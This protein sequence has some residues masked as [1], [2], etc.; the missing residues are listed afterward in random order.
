MS[1]EISCPNDDRLG[2]FVRGSL[3]ASDLEVFTEHI[4][5]CCACL[6]RVQSLLEDD[7]LIQVVRDARNIAPL[8]EDRE[9][10][11]RLCAMFATTISACPM[12]VPSQP[13]GAL[14]K[15]HLPPSEWPQ[16][17]GYRILRELGHGGMGAVYCARDENMQRLVAIK[18]IKG[19]FAT[20]ELLHRFNREI[21]LLAGVE[22][23]HIMKV[24]SVGEWQASAEDRML[25]Y[26][27]L[28]YVDGPD[29][30]KCLGKKPADPVEAAKLVRLLARAVQAIHDAGII[31]RDLK[32]ANVLL[33]PRADEPA[34]NSFWGCPKVADFGL[35][36]SLNST[37]VLTQS[38]VVLGTPAYMAPEQA[39]GKEAGKPADVYALGAI[40]YRMLTGKPPFTG[41]GIEIIYRVRNNSPDPP[42]ADPILPLD[43][44]IICLKCLEKEPSERYASASEL[45]EDLTRFL[46]RRRIHALPASAA[47][48][49]INDPKTVVIENQAAPPGIMPQDIH[50]NLIPSLV[51]P[52]P[53]G[54]ED[55]A[56]HQWKD[57]VHQAE[58]ERAAKG[59]RWLH[60]SDIFSLRACAGP[61]GGVRWHKLKLDLVPCQYSRWYYPNKMFD[62]PVSAAGPTW[63]E[64][65]GFNRWLLSP[66]SLE[67]HAWLQVRLGVGVIIVTED[68]KVVLPIRSRFVSEGLPNTYSCSIDETVFADDTL[69]KVAGLLGMT[70][71]RIEA[72]AP[73]PVATV[74]RALEKELGLVPGQHY[75]PNGLRLLAVTLS[76][77]DVC[78][79]L[80]LFL[81]TNCPSHTV[82]DQWR[83]SPH[84]SDRNENAEILTPCWEEE[85]AAALVNGEYTHRDGRDGKHV[86]RHAHVRV[87]FGF[88][89]ARH[90]RRPAR[91][92][93]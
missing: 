84:A 52:L 86:Y 23:Q 16:I 45:A 17:P 27:V 68:N 11:E 15:T 70:V 66:D 7:P 81:K 5:R 44:S 33:A 92:N 76:R 13:S 30:E 53:N 58:V 69:G 78:C 48:G 14:P 41:D 83:H 8:T 37:S 93:P 59:G 36:R 10:Q 24:H 88:D 74:I 51:E 47:H 73:S 49:L 72:N 80:Y 20:P 19:H 54:L 90:Y 79:S 87:R 60:E 26:L 1:I 85:V 6:Q 89:F 32:P 65:L 12:P 55:E 91:S 77:D 62:R 64:A 57:A 43:L 56:R 2:E 71:S 40:L 34:L 35:A 42:H 31:H 75:D 50:C 29:L 28:E 39:W 21:R 18:V 46:N 3:C 4:E 25:P 22:H 67:R 82:V 9:L 61:R 38:L 63:A